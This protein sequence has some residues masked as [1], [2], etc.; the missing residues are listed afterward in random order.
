MRIFMWKLLE[1]DCTLYREYQD[2][3]IMNTRAVKTLRMDHL[4]NHP[5][6]MRVGVHSGSAVAGIVGMT[7]PRFCVFGDTVN[8]A[9]KMEASG[10]AGRIHIS[11]T[12]KEL[13]QR[14]YPNQ[15]SIF[16]RGETLIKGIGPMYTHWLSLPEEASTFEP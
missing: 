7:A 13:L 14:H 10:R 11:I 9:A 1:T 2:E 4:P 16:E 15:F 8:L 5:I 12:T 6:Q 3:T